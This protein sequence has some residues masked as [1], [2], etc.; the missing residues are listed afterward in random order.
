MSEMVRDYSRV[1]PTEYHDVAQNAR[2][3]AVLHSVCVELTR[4]TGGWIERTPELPE[5]L[6]LGF[7]TFE[8]AEAAADL[9]GRLREL[10]ASDAEIE[11]NLRRTARALVALERAEDCHAFVAGLARVVKPALVGDLRRHL[12]AAPPYVDEPSVRILKRVIAEQ[13]GHIAKLL[14]LLADRQ[15]GWGAHR[16]FAE[17]VLEGLWDLHAPDGGLTAGL[18]VGKDPITLDRPAWPSSVRQLAYEDP[19]DPYPQEFEPAMRRCVHDLVFSEVEA[20]EIF[21]HYV[22]AFADA[23]LPWEFHRAAARIAWDE[24]R[25][26]ELLLNVLE[27]YDGTLGEFPAKAPGYEEYV[28]Q[29]TIVE[30][31]IMVNVIAEGEVSTDT[32]TQHRDAFRQLGDEL[33]ATLKDYEMADEVVHGR[34]GLV[35]SRWLADR[36]GEDWSAAYQRAFQALEDFKSQHDDEGGDSPIPLVR[37]GVDETGA[38]RVLNIEAKKLVGFSDE[39]IARL[40]EQAGSAVEA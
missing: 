12:D 36:N 8:D 16:E 25:H 18:F 29:D 1:V 33:S 26:V 21:G 2:R 32:Q 22:Y 11:A 4:L 7:I 5:K 20:L 9:E 38:K 27:R 40:R 19:G 24:A 10:R 6:A 34:F 31:L 13:E 39:E 17:Q 23:E 3:L 14:A 35:W 37:L 15:V 30:K 28:R